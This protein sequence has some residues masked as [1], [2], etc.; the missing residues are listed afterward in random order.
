MSSRVLRGVL[1]LIIAATLAAVCFAQ[2][3]STARIDG[4]VQDATGA[5]VPNAKITITNVN[6][7]QTTETTSNAAGAF[8]IAALQPGK[9]T[10]TVEAAGF[11]KTVVNDIEL[12]VDA[13]LSQKVTLEVGQVTE[14]VEVLAN[15]VSVQTTDSQV[16]RTITMRDI[17]TL[18]QLA[19]TP[20]SLA[21]FQPGVQITQ[22]GSSA[23]VDNSFSRINGNRQG[24]NNNTLDGIDANDAVAPRLGLS[25]TANNT[26]SVGEFRVITEGSKAEYGRNAGGQIELITRSGTNQY[27]GN[28]FDYLRNT[29]LNANDFFNNASG[30][31]RPL[32]IQNIFGGSFGGPIKH[33]KLFIFGNYQGRRTHQT[34][35]RNRTVPT[36]L[37]K[38]GIFQYH[39][40]NAPTTTAQVNIL[41]IDPRKLGIDPFMA[42]LLKIFPSPNNFDVGD[43]LNT[44]GFRF[45][46]PNDSKEDQFTIKADYN[47]TEKMHFFFRES[48]QRNT[49]IDS[50]NSAD[51]NFP[52]QAQGSQGGHRWGVAGGY[53]WTISPS[54][55]NEFRYGHQ[56]AS[57]SFVR[58]E[59]IA[60]PQVSV[61]NDGWTAP[62]NA[63]FAQGRN[64]P[65]NEYTDNI[66]KVH[67]NHTFK[68]GANFRFTKQFGFN[69][70]GIFANY[71]LSTANGNL[72]PTAL[73]P[74]NITTTDLTTFQGLYNNLLGRVS[75]INQTFLSNLSTYQA[76]GTTSVRNYIFHEYGFFIQDD[77]KVRRN[78]TFNL[79]LRYEFSGVPYE[80]GGQQ[81]QIANSNLINAA[82]NLTGTTIQ[83]TSQWYNNDWNNFAPRF[84]FAWDPK[85]DGKMAIRGSY[86]IYYDRIIGATTSLVD[87]NT[88][89][90][91]ANPL[92]P[93]TPNSVAG[94]DV[95]I[96]DNPALPQQPT[97]IVTTLPE[98][99][100]FTPV[101]F[102]PN[103]ATGY[104]QQYT[105]TVQRELAKNTVL[106]AGYLGNRGIKLFIDEDLNQPRIYG[107][108]LNSVNQITANI[109]NLSAV[110]ASNTLV[111]IFG[112][113]SAAVSALGATNF[114]NGLANTLANNLDGVAANFNKYSAAGVSSFYLRNFPQYSQLFYGTN[115]GRSYYDSL[116]ASVRRSAGALRMSANY[117]FSK[118]MDNLT[119]EG[120]GTGSLIDNFNIGLNR[121][122][123]DFDHP[124]VFSATGIYTLPIGKG[125]RFGGD[126][127][128][129][130]NTILGGW[131]FGSLMI[132]ESGS[133]MTVSSGRATGPSTAAT[134][135]NYSGDRN[136][137]DVLRQGN[138]VF[139]FSPAQI[140]TLTDPGNF[141]VA[142]SIGTSGR[143]S[144][145]GPRY[146]NI[147]SS[148]VKKFALTERQSVSFRAEAYNLINNVNFANPSLSIA[149][150]QSFGKIASTVAN[151][152]I[153]QG[154]LRY[155][156]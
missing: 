150:P 149:T 68:A 131:D 34:I 147:D 63:G 119:S 23:G 126:M 57:V 31:G 33:N 28:L 156:F 95:R 154:A 91:F 49:A 102:K 4:S 145:R 2:S 60:G 82:A 38:S 129:W 127:P 155:D 148:L 83:K 153:L 130:A 103:L 90:F 141:P 140:A 104:V 77:W 53:D 142:G 123:A 108:F 10:M 78:L 55:V 69:D 100:G 79:G 138:G 12:D 89:G 135:I 143:N 66:T 61:F 76:P 125:H 16:S 110:P 6:T 35:V 5:I 42:N 133:P 41:A 36:D 43:G 101:V 15:T 70:S 47:M 106:E 114:T 59:R 44:A 116:Q 21:I 13:Y 48:W 132:W 81:G 40:T 92:I 52:G 32:F 118:S 18:P 17:D 134:W 56:S 144:F 152:R 62:L 45:N 37:A 121:A 146:F 151:A 65:V 117:T 122:R 14:S 139:Y 86:G 93:D 88:P 84:G 27:H 3:T 29:D 19:R 97:T 137:G 11:R 94:S 98:T 58:P 20:I 72:P 46:N 136:I 71:S 22:N 113:A 96:R 107:D 80:T 115:D 1:F 30:V 109:N 73:N 112:S 87:G 50:L 51:A 124:H 25:L 111:R 64:S 39:P 74:A 9:Y 128:R 120:N 54:L 7:R 105:L 67:G 85:G 24:S 99:R 75:I 8:G 26:D